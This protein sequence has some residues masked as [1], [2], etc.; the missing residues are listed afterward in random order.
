MADFYPTPPY[1]F[2]TLEGV[3]LKLDPKRNPI[4]KDTV[5]TSWMKGGATNKDTRNQALATFFRDGQLVELEN[6]FILTGEEEDDFNAALQNMPP[7]WAGKIFMARK[8]QDSGVV[9]MKSTGTLIWNANEE[10]TSAK[11]SGS[12]SPTADSEVEIIYSGKLVT[13]Q[14][15]APKKLSK[16]AL[17]D[18]MAGMQEVLQL[19]VEGD[20]FSAAISH[21]YGYKERGVP[22]GGVPGYSTLV[23]NIRL[24]KVLTEGKPAAD[25]DTLLTKSAEN[26]ADVDTIYC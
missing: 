13:G 24:N 25:R 17:K 2:Y 10:D 18:L 3:M 5:I 7:V 1:D 4:D 19:M 16:F 11:P 23:F 20:N 9:K 26:D 12:K 21:E 6:K 15:F 14:E 8:A 22:G